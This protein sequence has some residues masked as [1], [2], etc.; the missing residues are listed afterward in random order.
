MTDYGIGPAD[1][2]QETEGTWRLDDDDTL[3]FFTGSSLKPRRV[4]RIASADSDRLVVRK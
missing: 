4:M 3:K 1:V 2:P